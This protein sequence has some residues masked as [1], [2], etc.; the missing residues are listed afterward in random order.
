MF[1]KP[2][3]KQL[4]SRK[5]TLFDSQTLVSIYFYIETPTKCQ[6]NYDDKIEAVPS[7]IQQETCNDQHDQSLH[8]SSLVI[9]KEESISKS[10]SNNK[11]F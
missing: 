9:V 1:I 4:A 8:Q 5:Q 6:G 7:V 11:L 10:N 3:E 2:Q